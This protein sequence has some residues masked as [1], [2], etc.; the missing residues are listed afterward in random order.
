[1]FETRAGGA[2]KF[3]NVATRWL[4]YARRKCLF[5]ETPAGESL[6]GGVLQSHTR[7]TLRCRTDALMRALP[8]DGR[9]LVK[10]RY[11]SVVSVAEGER[12]ETAERGTLTITVDK[13][14]VT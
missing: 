12:H 5:S 11:W 7:A 4:P 13:G 3:G 9:V 8:T 14:P 2:D 1:M 6:E 10:D